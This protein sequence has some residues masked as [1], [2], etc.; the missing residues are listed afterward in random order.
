MVVKIKKKSYWRKKDPQ[1]TRQ[2]W[3]L[4]DIWVFWACHLWKNIQNFL[5]KYFPK[6]KDP[7]NLK[8]DTI[9]STHFE[10]ENLG[11]VAEKLKF[12]FQ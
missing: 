8:N 11:L 10:S 6:D 2:I 9:I 5:L 4:K 12:G 3:V 7:L 1:I